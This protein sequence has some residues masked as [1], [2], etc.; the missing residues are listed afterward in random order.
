MPTTT[1]GYKIKNSTNQPDS[2]NVS[3][4]NVKGKLIRTLFNDFQNS[5]EYTLEWN[6]KNDDDVQVESGVYFYKLE[7]NGNQLETKK[8]LLLK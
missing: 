4:Y 5:G 8:M 3:I 7:I 6:G 2:V 1:I